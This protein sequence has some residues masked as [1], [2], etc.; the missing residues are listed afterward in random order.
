M[1][2][3]GNCAGQGPVRRGRLPKLRGVCCGSWCCGA[4]TGDLIREA[5]QGCDCA[6][7]PQIAQCGPHKWLRTK[8]GSRAFRPWRARSAVFRMESEGT[9]ANARRLIPG[10]L[11]AITGLNT[12]IE[13]EETMNQDDE[14]KL[15]SEYDFSSGVRGRHHEAYRRGTNVVVLSGDMAEVFEDSV[16]VQA[17]RADA[18]KARDPADAAGRMKGSMRMKKCRRGV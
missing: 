1:S 13:R 9:D 6:E 8:V 4:K 7:I 18:Q 16:A 2:A 5:A 10:R 14:G 12:R 15:Q 17:L 3:P 11:C